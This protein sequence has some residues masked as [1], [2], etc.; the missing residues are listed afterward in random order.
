M[1][2]RI[3][4]SQEEARRH[5]KEEKEHQQRAEGEQREAFKRMELDRMQNRE[6]EERELRERAE[7]DPQFKAELD[8]RQ[9]REQEERKASL[10][11]HTTLARTAKITMEQAIQI[12]NGQYP[13]KVMEC[14]LVGQGWESLGKLG[15]D[16][17]VFYHVVI[18][19]ADDPNP[20]FTHVM[21]N[22]LD[23][24]IYKTEKEERNP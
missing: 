1:V 20:T 23:G 6:T 24:S 8:A 9:R 3:Q 4:D 22:A 19:S 21:V 17:R 18:L 12:A 5:E 7:H 14:S 16:G 10:V 11:A 2:F 15:K 13:G